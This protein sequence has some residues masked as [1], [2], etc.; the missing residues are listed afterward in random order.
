MASLIDTLIETLIKENEEYETLLE[1]SMEKTGI[2]V[3]SDHEGLNEIVMKEQKVVE[4]I[5]VLEKKRSEVT[6][7]IGVVLNRKPQ[8]LTLTKLVEML[9]NQPRE[10]GMLISPWELCET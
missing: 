8:E 7:D 2:I 5:N 4:R 9:A 1:L 10:C 3:R 6:N